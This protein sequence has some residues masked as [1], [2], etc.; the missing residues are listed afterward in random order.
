MVGLKDIMDEFA[1][2]SGSLVRQP[3][4]RAMNPLKRNCHVTHNTAIANAHQLRQLILRTYSLLI[5]RNILRSICW[6]C[7]GF[8]LAVSTYHTEA[9]QE[10]FSNLTHMLYTEAASTVWSQYYKAG[11]SFLVMNV[12]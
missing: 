11:R 2:Q 12:P 7:L 4:R 5:L 9:Q 6:L 1:Q 3:V 10:W 8:Q